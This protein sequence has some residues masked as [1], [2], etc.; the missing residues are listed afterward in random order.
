MG[1]AHAVIPG[2]SLPVHQSRAGRPAARRSDGK[3][4]LSAGAATGQTVSRSERDVIHLEERQG[5]IGGLPE[6]EDEAHAA[7]LSGASGWPRRSGEPL[8]RR[9]RCPRLDLRGQERRTQRQ[10]LVAMLESPG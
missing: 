6:V 5:V 9:T 1:Q 2:G 3:F 7:A 8:R 4:R 10:P